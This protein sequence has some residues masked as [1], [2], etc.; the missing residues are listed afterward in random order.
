MKLK[1][2]VIILILMITILN[3]ENF[4]YTNSLINEDSPYLQQHAHNPVDWYAWNDVAFQKAKDENKLIFL[5]I[6]YSTCHWCHVME[7]ESFENEEIAKILNKDYISIK[8]DREEK[9]HIDKHYQDVYNLL[10]RQ[11]GGWPLTIIMTNEKKPFY[12]ATYLPPE[13]KFGRI[14]VK[15]L[16]NK[17]NYMYKNKNDEI[18]KSANSIEKALKNYTTKT[19]LKVKIKDELHDKFINNVEASFDKINKGIGTHPK[20]PHA[21]TMETLLDMYQITKNKKALNMAL[22]S[23]KAMAKGGIYDQVE[24]G[25]YRYSVDE[26]WMIPHFEKMLYTNA[27]LLSAYSKAYIITKDK[28]YKKIVDEIVTF[29]QERFNENN[30]LFSASDAD[31][32]S[33][34]NEKEEGYY[35]VF[36]YDDVEDAL[37]NN[38]YK[39]NEIK[40]IMNY[41]NITKHGNFEIDSNNPFLSDYN[42]PKNLKKIKK[43]LKDVRNK[44]EYPFIDNK[45]LTSWNAMYISSL[46]EAGKINNTYNTLAT[47]H[48]ESLLDN[49][50]IDKKLYHQKLPNKKPKE[51]A[52]FEDY[53]FLISA[54]L[55]AYENNLEQKY[56]NIANKFN[57]ITIEKFYKDEIWYMSDDEFKTSSGLYDSAYKS[58]TSNMIDNILKIAILNNDLKLQQLALTMVENNS[59]QLNEYP[60]NIPWMMRSYL[61]LKKG[62][63]VLKSKKANL[64]EKNFP[65]YPFFL[66]KETNDDI[67]LACKID[68]CFSYGKDF[69]IIEKDIEKHIIK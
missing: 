64:K 18:I 5:S 69:N 42:E 57:K 46:F 8:V 38:N 35:F 22:D 58:A 1:Q 51:L 13:D 47:S 41:F 48:L 25:F 7:E 2:I 12:A 55:K 3:S 26:K 24:G 68:I 27:E 17:L 20:F 34:E 43:I 54:L 53:S 10:N 60:N 66:R 32:I 63:I 16:L 65:K 36:Q 28:F 44:N 67:F 49:M 6:G 59:V 4:K 37:K 61:A 9:P 30:L 40:D 29:V 15:N 23:L 11:G 19:N 31:S 14:G 50:Y 56:L 33:Q 62:Y 39:Q 52:L 45:F 21:S